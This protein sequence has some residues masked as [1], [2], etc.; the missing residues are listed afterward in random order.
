M[1]QLTRFIGIIFV[2]LGIYGCQYEILDPGWRGYFGDMPEETS[3]GANT[4]GCYISGELVASGEVPQKEGLKETW[5]WPR[6]VNGFWD[7]YS[8]SYQI[9]DTWM[10]KD[11]TYTKMRLDF[12]GKNHTL[13]LTI[14]DIPVVGTH[15]C[16]FWLRFSSSESSGIVFQSPVEITTFDTVNQIISGR[17]NEDVDWGD[18]II[19]ITEGQFDI[20][21][22]KNF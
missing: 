2:V 5:W 6:F 19:H 9:P 1:K 21:Y 10:F 12:Q 7:R 4:F 20:K 17:F 18:S 3:V 13:Q 11:T 8:D 14:S 16:R 22:G 15:D